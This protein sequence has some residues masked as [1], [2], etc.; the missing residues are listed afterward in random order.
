MTTPHNGRPRPLADHEMPWCVLCGLGPMPVV[1]E[2]PDG[3]LAHPGCADDPVF[4]DLLPD[5]E[6]AHDNAR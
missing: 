6:A 3:C 1:I 2:L 4:A 5:H